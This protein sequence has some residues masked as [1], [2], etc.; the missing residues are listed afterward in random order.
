M[1]TTTPMDAS[2]AIFWD[3]RNPPVELMEI[4]YR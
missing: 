4:G 3:E 1:K 2:A